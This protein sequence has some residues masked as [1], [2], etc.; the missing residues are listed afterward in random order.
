MY[1]NETFNKTC[2]INIFR[3]RGD[4]SSPPRKLLAVMTPVGVGIV[5]YFKTLFSLSFTVAMFISPIGKRC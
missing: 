1:Q 3:K 2:K 5:A 4:V